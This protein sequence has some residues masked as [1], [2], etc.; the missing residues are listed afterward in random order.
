MSQAQR[1]SGN[2]PLAYMGVDPVSPPQFV[3]EQRAPET[4]DSQNYTLGAWW[5]WQPEQRLYYLVSLSGREATWVEFVAGSANQY[6][7]DNGTA[8]PVDG[9]LNVLGDGN[10]LTTSATGNTITIEPGA[11][12]LTQID[13]DTGSATPENGVIYILGGDNINTTGDDASTLFIALSTSITQ[14]NTNL[15]GSEGMYSLGGNRFM[16]NFGTNNTFLGTAAGNLSISGENSVGIGTNALLSLTSGNYNTAIGT[17]SQA[18]ATTGTENTSLGALSLASCTTGGENVAIGSAAL[19]SLSSGSQ[20]VVVGANAGLVL[21]DGSENTLIGDQAGSNY[22]TNESSNIL[23]GNAGTMGESN[24]LRIGAE[25]SAGSGIDSAYVAGIYGR[26]VGNTN[27]AVIIDST[28]KLGTSNERKSAFS[29]YLNPGVN[30]VTGDGTAYTILFDNEDFDIL[31]DYDPTTGMFT[32]P[33]DGKYQFYA[34][35]NYTVPGGSGTTDAALEIVT[36]T[37]TFFGDTLP[38]RNQ[39]TGF[40]AVNNGLHMQVSCFHQMSAG[41]TAHV[42]FAAQGGTRTTSLIS[43]PMGGGENCWFYG[44]LMFD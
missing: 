18:N 28:G 27:S 38:T 39:C 33:V 7:T 11:E 34:V 36:T 20:N 9:I 12:L 31:G 41:D 2:N 32:A 21:F 1:L 17:Q 37:R 19:Q 44:M 8:I 25:F 15:T 30:N 42:V 29:A 22:T 24:V 4:H 13:G 35:V 6:V 5:L 40:F 43:P 23:I 26:A 10:Y 16:H 14:P 3:I